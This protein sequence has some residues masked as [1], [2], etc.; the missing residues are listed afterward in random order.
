MN[1][2]KKKFFIAGGLGFIGVSFVKKLLDAGAIVL[3]LDVVSYASNVNH[4]SYFANYKNYEF[5]QGDISERDLVQSAINTFSPDFVV[6]IAAETHVDNSIHDADIFI[7]TNILGTYNVLTSAY[8]L[9]CQLPTGRKNAFRFLQ[10]STDEVFGALTFQSPRFTE[11]TPYSPRS[12]YAAT[13]AAGDHLASAW[14][15]TYRFPSLISNCSNNYGPN[16]H[17]EKLIP[18]IIDK[19]MKFESI[20]I[21]G[22]GEQIRDWIHV[23]DHVDALFRILESAPVGSR[24]NIGAGRELTNKQMVLAVC[25][26]LD[27]LLDEKPY[28]GF[29]S[30]IK[31]VDDRPGHDLRY[32]VDAS[33]LENELNWRPKVNFEDGLRSTVEWYVQHY[34]QMLTAPVS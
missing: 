10:I 13:K 18:T 5:I 4:I 34:R 3:N 16:Q 11:L 23:D 31:F 19:A 12:P 24:Y 25:D 1:F 26:V 29:G 27:V 22:T 33:K 17:K 28:G 32:G 20:P 14:F 21:Y 7:T 8:S 30:L 2:N 15:H 9:W 6:N